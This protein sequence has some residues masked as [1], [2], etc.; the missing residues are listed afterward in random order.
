MSLHVGIRDIR[1][2]T[3]VEAALVGPHDVVDEAVAVSARPAARARPALLAAAARPRTV[4]PVP[5]AHASLQKIKAQSSI[6]STTNS[7][8][9][10]LIHSDWHA[11]P[12][13]STNRLPACHEHAAS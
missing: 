13:G 6:M 2:A 4:A 5:L 7:T 8:M 12:G 1:A 3:Q 11:V 10:P 9:L